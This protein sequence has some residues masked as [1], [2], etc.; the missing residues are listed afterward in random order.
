M[1]AVTAAELTVE[2]TATDV[3]KRYTGIY[4]PLGMLAKHTLGQRPSYLLKR[5]NVV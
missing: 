5:S 4:S 3:M 2:G 1:F